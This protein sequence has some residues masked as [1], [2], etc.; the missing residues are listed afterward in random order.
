MSSRKLPRRQF[1][2][3]SATAAVWSTQ[4]SRF[5]H[6]GWSEA[7]LQEYGIMAGE[8][9]ESTAVIWGRADQESSMVV[10]WDTDPEFP[11]PKAKSGPSVSGLTDFTGHCRL[12]GLPAGQRVFYR[13]TFRNASGA[14]SHDTLGSFET[15]SPSPEDVFFAWSGDTA[16]QGFGINLEWGGMRIYEAIEKLAPQ[17]FVHS[18]DMI[19]ADNPIPKE[20]PL[21]DGTVWTNLVTPAKSHAASTLSDFRGNYLYNLLDA[22]LQS[23]HRSVPLYVQWDDHETTNNWYPQQSLAARRDAKVYD[24]MEHASQLSE[25]ARQAFF[26]YTPIR[27]LPS[28]ERRIYRKVPRGPLLDLFLLD[29]RSHRGPNSTN[30]QTELND[31]AAIL[32]PEQL[33]WLKQSLSESRATWK[34]LCSDMPLGV[35]IGDSMEGKPY[36]EGVANGN[37]GVPMG[38]ELEMANLLAWIKS[39]EIKNTLWL[40]ADIHYAAAH[41]Y[42]PDRADRKLSFSPFWEFVAGP[43]HAGTFGPNALDGTFGPEVRF[44]WAPPAGTKLPLPPSAGMQSFGTVRIDG[45][46]Q[47]L[48]VELRGL[49]GAVLPNGAIEL[50]PESA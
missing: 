45:R 12:E 18:G 3:L 41:H 17:F 8:V 46:T 40:T 24:A 39:A 5:A 33:R 34:I 42:H 31:A 43:L 9:T 1:Q 21:A 20:V 25:R 6:A 23:F 30:D 29:L 26:E 4:W 14:T 49:D 19:Y 32:G 36:F 15:P 28:G 22:P 7:P 50:E 47:K 13:V 2:A 37:P 27:P 16:G 35:M 11:H 10:E 48:M 38:R 44:Q